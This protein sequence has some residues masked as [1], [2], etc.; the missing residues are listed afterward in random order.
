MS[1]VQ[2]GSQIDM[3][4][5][6][7]TE[8]GAGVAGTDAVN[9]DQ[10]TA[11]G[12]QGFAQNIGDGVLTTFTLTHSLGTLDVVTQVVEITTGNYIWADARVVS[13]SQVSV[14]FGAAPSTDQYR[15][16]IVPVP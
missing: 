15:V 13:T 1:G 12:P 6:K 3:N 14:S 8:L 11:S 16:L 9:V 10:L 7:I 4:G 5:L 2:F